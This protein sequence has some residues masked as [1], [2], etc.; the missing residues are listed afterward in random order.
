MRKLTELYKG[1][2]LSFYGIILT[3][4]NPTPEPPQSFKNKSNPLKKTLQ[5]PI[6]QTRC[7]MIKR[8]A[9]NSKY[10]ARYFGGKFIETTAIV[11]TCPFAHQSLATDCY[12]CTPLLDRSL[13]WQYGKE[14]HSTK[15]QAA[16]FG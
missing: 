12:C 1:L 6:F 13:R 7:L 15:E 2:L 14:G 9:L 8:D 5:K 16:Y 4:V 3:G 11:G 10:N